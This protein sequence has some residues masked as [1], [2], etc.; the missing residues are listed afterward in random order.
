MKAEALISETYIWPRPGDR[1]KLDTTQQNHPTGFSEFRLSRGKKR[2]QF[3][4]SGAN[5][6]LSTSLSQ[7]QPSGLNC[8]IVYSLAHLHKHSNHGKKLHMTLLKC[9]VLVTIPFEKCRTKLSTKVK[10]LK[11]TRLKN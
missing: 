1:T 11:W 7:T 2:I 10:M 3:F 6:F 8:L 9:F 4:S 5:F